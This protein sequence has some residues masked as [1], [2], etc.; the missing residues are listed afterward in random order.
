MFVDP[1]PKGGR[2]LINLEQ[3]KCEVPR[4]VLLLPIE[5]KEKLRKNSAGDYDELLCD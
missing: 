2:S 1:G 3:A 4:N 5:V